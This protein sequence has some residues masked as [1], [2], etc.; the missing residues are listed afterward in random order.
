MRQKLFDNLKN[1]DINQLHRV[2]D[3]Y[4]DFRKKE[5]LKK[6]IKKI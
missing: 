5:V 4:V 2:L 6:K 3:Q 1:C